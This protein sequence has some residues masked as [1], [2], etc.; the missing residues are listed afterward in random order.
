MDA[1][2][3]ATRNGA[4][5]IGAAD[6]IGSVQEG[7]FADLVAVDGDPLADVGQFEKVRFV[8]KGGVVYRKDGAPTAQ[9]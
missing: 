1:I 6:K 4:D 2:L 5:L 3:T 9:P 8:M 7:R